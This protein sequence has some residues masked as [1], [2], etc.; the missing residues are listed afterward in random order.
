MNKVKGALITSKVGEESANNFIII[1]G[2]ALFAIN[3]DVGHL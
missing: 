2:V 3:Q 1:H